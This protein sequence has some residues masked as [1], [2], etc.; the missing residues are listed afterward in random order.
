MRLNTKGSHTFTLT[1]SNPAW[2]GT[3]A[4]SCSIRVTAW[5][6]PTASIR[7]DRTTINEGQPFT[8][9][10]SSSNAASV[11]IDPGI[12]AVTPNVSGSRTLRP[13]QGRHT[14]TIT[15]SGPTQSPCSNAT[16]SVTVTVRPTPPGSISA[17]PNPCTIPSGS[18]SCTSTLSWSAQGTNGTLV[19]VSHLTRAFASSGATGSQ[20]ATWI[21]EAPAHTY[22][23]YL[24]DYHDRIKGAQLD[25]VTVT[26]QRPARP[27]INDLSP[28]DGVV[29]TAVTISGVNFGNTGSVTFNATYGSPSSWSDTSI[30]VEVPWGATSGPVVVRANGQDSNSVQFL[31]TQLQKEDP[32]G[33]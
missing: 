16:D 11:R 4:A 26:G 8:L 29:G 10:W 21:Q 5:D 30:S 15:A 25:S 33:K 31:V 17:S 24:Y 3:D 32:E 7:A 13:S 18:N 23:F 27:W 28:P 12:G 20:K 9:S 14:Y 6:R 1:A 2:T 19:E 22:I